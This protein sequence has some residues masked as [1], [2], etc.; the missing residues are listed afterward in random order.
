MNMKIIVLH[1]RY[2]NE[3]AIIRIDAIN[4][5]REVKDDGEVY[6]ELLINDMCFVAKE[7]IGIVMIKIRKA[8]SEEEIWQ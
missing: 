4:M 6:S 5:I 1:D 8:E 2:S 3:P 7:K